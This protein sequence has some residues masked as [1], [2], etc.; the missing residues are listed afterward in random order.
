MRDESRQAIQCM[1]FVCCESTPYSVVEYNSYEN[2]KYNLKVE[3]HFKLRIATCAII[4]KFA[5]VGFLGIL[6]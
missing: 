4:G 1:P 5:W 3:S 6:P 2:R